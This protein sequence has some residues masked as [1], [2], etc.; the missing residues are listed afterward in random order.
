GDDLPTYDDLAVQNG[1][2]SRFGRWREW[3]EKRSAERYADLTPDVLKQRRAR[4]WGDSVSNS[5]VSS[6]SGASGP[7]RHLHVQTDFSS[8]VQY[9]EPEA[10]LESTPVN[11][12]TPPPS[13]GDPL[14]PSHLELHQFGSRFLPHT[15]SPIRCLLPLLG[16]RL[17]LIGHD[18]GLSVMDLYPKEWN[19]HGLARKGPGDAEARQ[20][21]VG[22]GV[23]QMN[24]LE[25][26]STGE[27]T[28]QGVVLALVGPESN[29]SKEQEAVRSLRMYNLAS[30]VSL[31]KYS[32]VQRPGSRP[33]DLRH[34]TSGK[35]TQT[36]HRK[37][38]S[39]AKGIKNLI[40]E[41]P[42][43][44]SPASNPMYQARAET[45]TQL[46]SAV[47]SSPVSNRSLNRNESS[48]TLDSWDMVDDLPLRWATD[49]VPL[50]NAGS[51]LINSSVIT[52]A[53]YRDENQRS[54]GGAFLAVAVKGNILL[55]ETPKGERAFRFVKEFY[56][57]ISA[58]NLTFVHQTVQDVMSRSPSDVSHQ[59]HTLATPSSSRHPKR[60]S[61]GANT[62][63]QPQYPP[64]LSIFVVFE[65]KAGLIRIADSAVGEVDL[66][67]D[68]P[69]NNLL[70]SPGSLR[71]K[72]RSSWD[73]KG[74]LKESKAPWIPPIRIVVPGQSN[75]GW[76]SPSQNMYLLTR[77]KYSHVL[78]Y[79]LPANLSSIPPF[80]TFTWLSPPNNLAAR[81]CRPSRPQ[82]QEDGSTISGTF[83]QVIA[84]GEEGVEVQEIALSSLTVNANKNKGKGRAEEHPLRAVSD[85][86]GDTGFLCTGGHWNHDMA[87]PQFLRSDSTM[88]NDSVLE[89]LSSV[90]T[91]S[92][93]RER[94][95]VYGWVRK[96][97]EDWRVF[98][99]GGS[100]DRPTDFS[101][102]I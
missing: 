22:E 49:Y 92:R 37:G 64:Q 99:V 34:P 94:E 75:E 61:M 16:D 77:G 1:P 54:R 21:W 72:S 71:G 79:P 24:I 14:Y 50:A 2:N 74:F 28:P 15:T 90:R 97:A 29:C 32:V 73:G 43:P 67:D 38:G 13:I 7:P 19:D 102:T 23:F 41:S 42:P 84:F 76:T 66:Y 12:T 63:S 89:D 81:I 27:G 80:R 59:R 53:L 35:P 44:N 20:I 70:L 65:K 98:W 78:P 55:Y 26:E 100:G 62:L 3:I 83:L 31:A 86:G 93:L 4:G 18:D 11:D 39:L 30:L 68:A 52:Y 58:R 17:I 91:P 101:M 8:N 10:E 45:Y 51:R 9:S 87:K 48:A 88:S 33:L 6:S 60:L 85:I 96:G 40:I 46:P 5:S 36:M 56:T 47:E 95:G 69:H 82:T 25:S 57:P